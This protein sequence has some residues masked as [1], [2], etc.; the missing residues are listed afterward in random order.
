MIRNPSS[1]SMSASRKWPT[2]PPPP[3]SLRGQ[4]YWDFV[5]Y[6]FGQP[7]YFFFM[8]SWNSLSSVSPETCGSCGAKTCTLVFLKYFSMVWILLRFASSG[9]CGLVW[10]SLCHRMCRI[11]FGLWA[12]CCALMLCPGA[13]AAP[14]LVTISEIV[15]LRVHCTRTD[16]TT[17]TLLPHPASSCVVPSCRV[18]PNM[19]WHMLPWS[20]GGLMYLPANA[21]LRK[22]QQNTD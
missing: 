16:N 18:S 12:S 1:S 4:L 15:A 2:P 13:W 6:P 8:L 21:K 5:P 7:R 22:M 10:Q 14:G 3:H 19:R 11:Y 17:H 9:H 20:I